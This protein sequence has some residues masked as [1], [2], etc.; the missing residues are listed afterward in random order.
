MAASPPAGCQ[1]IDF[2]D[3]RERWPVPLPPGS[4]CPSRPPRQHKSVSGAPT[5]PHMVLIER[6][7]GQGAANI[8]T[9]SKSSHQ[10]ADS[11]RHLFQSVS[12]VVEQSERIQIPGKRSRPL[13][14]AQGSSV[15]I[16]A[17]L[18]VLHT[19][20]T[21]PAF[22]TPH[23]LM[24]CLSLKMSCLIRQYSSMAAQCKGVSQ[25][26]GLGQKEGFLS[27]DAVIT[28]SRATVS[29]LSVLSTDTL[30]H[31]LTTPVRG[32]VSSKPDE[33]NSYCK[34]NAEA[35]VRSCSH[36]HIRTEI[37]TD[38]W[39][40]Q[41]SQQIGSQTLHERGLKEKSFDK[42]SVSLSPLDKTKAYVH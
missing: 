5:K 7:E 12:H 19:N 15:G 39:S 32:A 33:L 26:K 11:C 35:Y 3:V 4:P 20:N 38:E 36:T 13:I 1:L 40:H 25:T 16:T 18:T 22:S 31:T 37:F 41:C 24:I 21:V 6:R 30:T 27:F 17:T 23:T 10:E 29:P 28:L 8:L 14:A 9:N 2:N 34:G 42:E